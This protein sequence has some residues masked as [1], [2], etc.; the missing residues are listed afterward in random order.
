M[1]SIWILSLS[2]LATSSQANVVANSIVA[3][4]DGS[5]E[6][7]LSLFYVV[8]LAMMFSGVGLLKKLGNRTAFMN[9]DSGVTGPL[10]RLGIG[11][12]LIFLP[13]FLTV[14]NN[15]IFGNPNLIPATGLAYGNSASTG[16]LAALRPIIMI[17]QFI[18]M[19]AM[20]RG[21]L[22]L[23]K[24]TGQGAQPGTISKGAVHIVGGILAVNVVRTVQ[25]VIGTFGIV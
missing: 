19:V 9:S 3:A 16:F 25:V 2:L 6:F 13:S 12:I 20:L 7:M 18:G 10:A 21:F 1:N 8:G 15:S 14:V 24:A 11:A 5:S 22:I 17:I 23:S 4:M